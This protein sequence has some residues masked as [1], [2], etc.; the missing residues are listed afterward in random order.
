[1]KKNNRTICI[2]GLGYV[3]LPLAVAF[4]RSPYKT[5][6]YDLNKGK[7]AFLK[8]GIDPNGEISE[9]EM[10]ATQIE[11]SDHP[12]I[13]K[14]ADIIIA[15]IPTPVDEANIP[16]LSPLD[17]ASKI[18]G[19]NLKKGAIVVF[20]STV[21]PGVTEEFCA[22]I[23]EKT[24]GLK[25]GKDFTLG[26][27]P[28]RINPGDK[29]HTIEN[30]IKIVSGSDAKTLKI[31]SQAYGSIIKAGIYE[32]PSMKV[33]EAAKVIENIQRDLNIGL[34][35]ELSMIFH[36][37]GIET[38]EVLKAAETKWNFHHYRPGLVGG[39][40]IGVDPYYLTYK[41]QELGYHP[42]VILAA[43]RVNDGM[44]EQAIEWLVQSLAKHGD[45][46]ISKSKVLILGVTFK[47]NV[48]DIRNS[49]VADLAQALKKYGIEVHAYDPI[50]KASD[51]EKYFKVK[52]VKNLQGEKIYDGIILASPHKEILKQVGAL[53]KIAKNACVFMD[54]KGILRDQL[55][56]KKNM[57]YCC[58]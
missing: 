35:N 34:I 16:D 56:N 22:P 36:R 40:C 49:K 10:G 14:K 52:A 30:I 15:A 57:I 8:K 33:A 1:M 2:V 43:R 53:E 28:E 27:S 31:V 45:Q 20:E 54:I 32:A 9:E 21:Y 38:Q 4:G 19:A 17:S 44:A 41:A 5:L 24:S 3:G 50:I 12:S 42:Q 7:I 13:I 39:H 11:F 51:I 6:G 48:A 18:I 37:M 58:L 26:Y 29:E 25:F 55:K 47:E 46:C 23:I